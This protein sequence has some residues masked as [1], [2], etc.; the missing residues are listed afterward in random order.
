[1]VATKGTRS[2]AVRPVRTLVG[3]AELSLVPTSTGG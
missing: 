3:H 1:V 2:M